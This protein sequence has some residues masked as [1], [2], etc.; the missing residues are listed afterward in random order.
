MNI[1]AG[2]GLRWIARSARLAPR[3]SRYGSGG[4]RLLRS[5]KHRRSS[6]TALPG[7][8]RHLRVGAPRIWTG[9]TA[10]SA[11]G[12]VL[13]S[14]PVLLPSFAAL[15]RGELPLAFGVDQA[16]I[17]ENACIRRVRPCV[18]WALVALN[19]VCLTRGKHVQNVGSYAT[20]IPAAL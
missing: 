12:C 1:V 13:G 9:G 15:R 20:F 5:A 10:S 6:R 4:R 16:E 14:K 19:I 7:A 3:L 18:L 11:A 8:G 17:A 2:V